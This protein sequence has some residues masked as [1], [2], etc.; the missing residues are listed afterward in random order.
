M[1]YGRLTKLPVDPDPLAK[2]MH[3]GSERSMADKL[4]TIGSDS[5]FAIS[6]SDLF[7]LLGVVVAI[8]MSYAMAS[9]RLSLIEKGIRDGQDSVVRLE[10]RVQDLE[11]HFSD[12]ESQANDAFHEYDL[13]LQ[14]IEE[15]M[16][17]QSRSS[18]VS[19][20]RPSYPEQAPPVNT[21]PH[22]D[23]QIHTAPTY[24]QNS[25]TNAQATEDARKRAAQYRSTKF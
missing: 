25:S 13:R 11:G 2:Y 3:K 22:N 23:G 18:G 17:G 15:R 6:M 12:H 9:S 10:S 7:K 16:F 20:G 4:T 24:Y 5:K 1:H 19:R 14:S 21:P 8:G